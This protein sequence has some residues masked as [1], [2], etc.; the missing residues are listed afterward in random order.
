MQDLNGNPIKKEITRIAY[1]D[2]KDKPSYYN[3]D[4]YFR[5]RTPNPIKIDDKAY[6]KNIPNEKD[7]NVYRP[8]RV[9]N[10]D[11]KRDYDTAF[12]DE[13]SIKAMIPLGMWVKVL[14][15]SRDYLECVIKRTVVNTQNRAVEKDEEETV[16]IYAAIP[17][18]E[19]A[20][21]GQTTQLD[22]YTRDDLDLKDF[23]PVEFQLIDLSIEKLMSVSVGG[24]FRRVK[25]SDVIKALIT[26]TVENIKVNDDAKAIEA[27][28][29]IDADNTETREH[30]VIGDNLPLLQL[31]QYVQQKAG[32]VYS[33]GL[34][35]YIQDR[36]WY[37]FPTYNTKRLD[38]ESRTL[39]VV[40]IPSRYYDEIE[41]TYRK[42]GDKLFILAS[43]ESEFAD[44]GDEEYRAL[45]S[46]VRF[47]DAKSYMSQ[48]V[49]TKDNKALAH[50]A[51]LNN[52]YLV[53]DLKVRSS[54]LNKV[55]SSSEPINANPFHENSKLASRSGS[56]YSFVWNRADATL[57]YPGMPAKILYTF[58]GDILEL[59]GTVLK[60]HAS[61]QQS[62][63][64]MTVKAFDNQTVLAVYVDKTNEDT[65]QKA[66]K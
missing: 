48:L 46:G 21:V 25:P 34:S 55:P 56:W 45:G 65:D 9:T 15:P 6:S 8:L 5:I 51:K 20:N 63:P 13:V 38:K 27:L 22:R 50:R 37:I 44:R 42:D 53:K 1:P 54:S 64:G 33:L 26:K 28:N 39:V 66:S 10:I 61:I 32:G 58:E 40:K 18:T 23:I 59:H 60:V 49:E 19:V 17:K 30:I 2:P 16:F 3:Y 29:F 57:I 31:P 52:E 41:S 35:S 11:F 4:V 36:R 7:R 62:V 14:Q 47:A 12:A 43:S 24:I